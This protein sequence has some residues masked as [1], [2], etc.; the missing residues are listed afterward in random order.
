LHMQWAT[1]SHANL[2]IGLAAPRT[3][4]VLVVKP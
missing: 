1:L 4:S 2:P 3:L